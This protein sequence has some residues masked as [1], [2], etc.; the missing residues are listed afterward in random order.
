MSQS[1][2]H[3]RLLERM[4]PRA[5]MLAQRWLTKKGGASFSAIDRR[6]GGSK[7]GG[8]PALKLGRHVET[9]N[10]RG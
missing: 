5:G 1:S 3:S 4:P 2:R 8:D 10:A 6:L 9:P 7:T